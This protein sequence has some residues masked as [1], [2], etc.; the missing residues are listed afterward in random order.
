MFPAWARH[1]AC[2]PGA[3]ARSRPWPPGTGPDQKSSRPPCCQLPECWEAGRV[4]AGRAAPLGTSREAF[5]SRD[6]QR[7]LLAA[8]LDAEWEAP[9]FG[10]QIPVPSLQDGY[11][12]RTRSSHEA[13]GR[14]THRPDRAWMVAALPEGSGA[15]RPD[16]EGMEEAHYRGCRCGGGC[17]CSKDRATPLP[18]GPWSEPGSAAAGCIPHHVPVGLAELH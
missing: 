15:W 4:Q 9:L 12:S 18:L 7:W 5:P 13:G 16:G 10:I 6:L 17:A 11:F 1:R 3:A 8:L 14:G 2:E